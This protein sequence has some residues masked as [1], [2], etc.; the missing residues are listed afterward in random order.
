MT[1]INESV[2]EEELR[3]ERQVRALTLRNAGATFRQIADKTGVSPTQ[4]R[5]DVEVALREVVAESAESMIARQRAVLH[6]IVRA[7]YAAAASGDIDA[8]RVILSTLEREAKLFGLDAPT[9]VSVGV[10]DVEFA[11]RTASLIES[12]GLSPPRE[13]A[14]MGSRWREEILD[15]QADEVVESAE[16]GAGVAVLD[17]GTSVPAGP[18]SNI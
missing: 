14:V 3:I 11:E 8:A 12:L 4:A 16:G 13:L 10:S 9:R 7:N 15:V 6:D 17:G 2:P 5:K 1:T 18:W